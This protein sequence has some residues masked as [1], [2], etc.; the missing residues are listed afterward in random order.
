MRIRHDTLSIPSALRLLEIEWNISLCFVF[1]RDTPK[2][3]RLT[4][5]FGLED[6]IRYSGY[7]CHL[8][9]GL[10]VRTESNAPNVP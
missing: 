5:S 7:Y 10:A 3:E 4:F 8:A 2:A 9:W 1:R 6:E